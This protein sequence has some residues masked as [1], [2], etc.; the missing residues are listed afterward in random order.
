MLARVFNMELV[1]SLLA[2][3]E[4]SLG[5]VKQLGNVTQL[6]SGRETSIKVF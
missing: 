1:L 3:K 5:L 2:Y 6:V 4:L